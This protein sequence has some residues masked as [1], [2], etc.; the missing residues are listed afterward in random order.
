MKATSFHGD[1][2]EFGGQVHD[3]LGKFDKMC[4]VGAREV[5]A[6]LGRG[7][8]SGRVGEA[9]SGEAHVG[10]GGRG[11]AKNKQYIGKAQSGGEVC[12][13]K[14]TFGEHWRISMAQQR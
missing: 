10:T 1:L 6:R 11:V 8:V 7:H 12:L 5:G 9:P 2:V 3:R 14:S 4:K 13:C